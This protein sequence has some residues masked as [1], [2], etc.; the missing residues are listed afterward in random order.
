VWWSLLPGRIEEIDFA[1]LRMLTVF[2]AVCSVVVAAIWCTR[3]PEWQRREASDLAVSICAIAYLVYGMVIAAFFLVEDALRPEMA[4]F[5][6][7]KRFGMSL[8][9][10]GFL[11]F[12]AIVTT[13]VPVLV[14]EIA[15]V[16]FVRRRWAAAVSSKVVP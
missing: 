15:V 7:V 5:S 8:A 11:I 14:A 3:E 10:S 12:L 6:R 1:Q 2:P 16:R 13:A 4:D 9:M